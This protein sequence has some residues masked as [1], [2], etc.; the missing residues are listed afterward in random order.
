MKILDVSSVTDSAQIKIKKG[1]LQFLQDANYEAFASVVKAAIGPTYDPTKVYI[2]HGVINTGTGSS[3]AISA[4]AVFYNGE[5]FQVDAVSF[6]TSG[7]QVAVFEII[8]SQYTSNADPVTFTDASVHNVHNIR[9]MRIYSA[10]SGSTLANFS[11][12][13]SFSFYVSPQLNLTVAGALN[14][15]GS[16]PNLK[17]EVPATHSR[18]GALYSSSYLVGDIGPGDTISFTI[19]F[20]TVGTSE[21]FVMGTIVSGAANQSYDV[22]M[23]NIR[24]RTATSF[25]VHMRQG[26]SWTQNITFDFILFAK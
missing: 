21:Y 8:T 2:L 7:S 13:S 25:D 14:L 17:L 22:C 15:T 10:T 23:W 24:N 3:Y 26:G 5:I 11:D 4:G 19:T 9:K 12:G 20:P 1:T 16:Y 6:S 18:N